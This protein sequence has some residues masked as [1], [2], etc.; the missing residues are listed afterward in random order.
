MINFYA[1]FLPTKAMVLKFTPQQKS[2]GFNRLASS[3]ASSLSASFS[4]RSLR[5]SN[6]RI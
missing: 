4:R 2:G 1:R 6:P 5:D 3:L